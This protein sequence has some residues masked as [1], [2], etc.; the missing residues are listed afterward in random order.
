[1][2]FCWGGVNSFCVSLNRLSQSILDVGTYSR[3]PCRYDAPRPF[4]RC[5][6][7]RHNSLSIWAEGYS[8][9]RIHD[10]GYVR[11]DLSSRLDRHTEWPRRVSVTGRLFER[12]A[13]L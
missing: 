7:S 4:S 5:G 8:V 2:S 13:G 12:R 3:Q 9:N 11:S 10:G 6:T 1:M